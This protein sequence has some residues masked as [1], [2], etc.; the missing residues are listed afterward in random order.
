LTAVVAVV[1]QARLELLLYQIVLAQAVLACKLQYQEQQLIM[2]AVAVVQQVW[3]VLTLALAA[4]AAAV[5]AALMVLVWL[6]ELSTLAVVAVVRV[7]QA[8]Q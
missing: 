2:Q 5:G 4:Q 8:E 3:V 7:R 1:A 6:M